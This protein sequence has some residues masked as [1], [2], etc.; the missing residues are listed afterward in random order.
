MAAPQPQQIEASE[1]N[2]LDIRLHIHPPG[3]LSRK[4]FVLDQLSKAELEKKKRCGHCSKGICPP[5]QARKDPMRILA[6]DSFI[7]QLLVLG[8]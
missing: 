8:S 5:P 3:L 2:V 1:G 4:G 7:I 6:D